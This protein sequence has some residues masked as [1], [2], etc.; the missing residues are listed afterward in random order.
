MFVYCTRELHFSEAAA[1]KRI[2]AARAARRHPELL[3]AVRQGDLHVTAVSLLAA[4][5]T[6]ESCAEW[7]RATMW[8]RSAPVFARR[9]FPS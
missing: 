1:Y 4:Q 9:C 8:M 6:G 5:L 2:R 3:E 7:I